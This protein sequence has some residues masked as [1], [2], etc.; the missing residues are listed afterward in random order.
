MDK[1][2]IV[3]FMLSWLLLMSVIFHIMTYFAIINKSESVSDLNMLC[4]IEKR[5]DHINNL[6]LV[7]SKIDEVVE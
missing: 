4:K 2:S 1:K 6:V 3:I 5:L 7:C